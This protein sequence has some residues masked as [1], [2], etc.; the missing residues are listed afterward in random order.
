MDCVVDQFNRVHMKGYR[1]RALSAVSERTT[2]W[3]PVSSWFLGG[4]KGIYYTGII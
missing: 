3:I 2:A 1:C 4:N